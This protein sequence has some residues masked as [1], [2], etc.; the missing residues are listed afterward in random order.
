MDATIEDLTVARVPGAEWPSWLTDR[1][2]TCLRVLT[3]PAEPDAAVAEAVRQLATLPG[4]TAAYLTPQTDP[5][6]DPDTTSGSLRILAGTAHLLELTGPAAYRPDVVQGAG[7]VAAAMVATLGQ[8][9][10]PPTLERRSRELEELA[11]LKS[12][13]LATVAHELRTPLTSASSLLQLMADDELTESGTVVEAVRRNIERLVATVEDLLLLARIEADQLP[14]D[15]RPV[16]TG[17]LLGELLD[18]LRVA[19][20]GRGVSIRTTSDESEPTARVL[21]DAHWLAQMIGYLVSGSLGSGQPGALT[22]HGTVRD[23]YWTLSVSGDSL[24]TTAY[25]LA[26]VSD[27]ESGIGIGLGV[28][29]ARAI[30]KRHGG[31]LRIEHGTASTRIQIALPVI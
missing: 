3:D 12:E 1:I 6:T 21:G 17:A 4:V 9:L 5:E 18:P 16:E 13:F 29:L 15:R 25:R 8:A 7:L 11:V 30:A 10:A 22:V 19:A 23:G 26:E 2:A 31:E 28:T 14:L 20:T 27:D 24:H